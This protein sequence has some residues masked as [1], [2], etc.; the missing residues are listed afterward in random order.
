MQPTLKLMKTI[1]TQANKTNTKMIFSVNIC[2]VCANQ[3]LFCGLCSKLFNSPDTASSANVESYFKNV[4]QSLSSV[5]PCRV[6]KLVC[7]HIE[8]MNGLVKESSLTYVNFI[9]AAG[10]LSNVLNNELES[11]GYD[12]ESE[13]INYGKND[14]AELNLPTNDFEDELTQNNESHLDNQLAT[15]CVACKNGD[16]PTGAHKCIKCAKFVHIFDGCSLSCGEDEGYGEGRICVACF[17]PVPKPTSTRRS[18]TPP[19]K[20]T[21][22]V[23]NEKEKW[24]KKRARSAHSYLNPVRNWNVDQRVQS[25]PKINMFLNGS[26]STTTHKVGKEYVVARNTCAFDSI[27]QVNSL[28]SLLPKIY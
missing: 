24:G 2:S 1:V 19:A 20:T 7:A 23:L 21:A 12:S 11:L 13:L 25:K 15:N 16:A 4:K 27:C 3:F 26:L 22:K 10:G 14:N 28:F 5:I 6:D 18:V 17:K 8:M 9:D